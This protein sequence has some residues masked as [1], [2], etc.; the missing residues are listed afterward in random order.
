MTKVRKALEDAAKKKSPRPA[1]NSAAWKKQIL[2]ERL[3]EFMEQKNMTLQSTAKL[4]QEKLQGETFNPVNLS[5]YRAGRSFP[6]PRILKALSDVLGVPPD[7]LIPGLPSD[8]WQSD[9][10]PLN[11]PTANEASSTLTVKPNTDPSKKER[12]TAVPAFNIEDLE[13][14]EAWLQIN[15]RLSWPTVIKI[16]DILKGENQS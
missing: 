10:T 12:A 13:G 4:M 2:S 8:E 6:R 11:A 7:Q 14:G 15:Q 3:R 16:L 5:H 9:D 1:I